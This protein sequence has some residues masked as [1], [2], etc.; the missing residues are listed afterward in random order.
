MCYFHHLIVDSARQL[1]EAAR[2]EQQTLPL[3]LIGP[4]SFELP[5]GLSF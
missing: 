5:R 3:P 4:N 1:E 2:A